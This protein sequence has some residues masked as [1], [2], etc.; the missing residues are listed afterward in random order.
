MRY[1]CVLEINGHPDSKDCQGVSSVI[2]IPTTHI[3]AHA[4][5]CVC[6]ASID[7]TIYLT[8]NNKKNTQNNNNTTTNK[9]NTYQTTNSKQ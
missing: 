2:A 5:V 7:Q 9:N 8:K 4:R 1:T 3:H 6:P